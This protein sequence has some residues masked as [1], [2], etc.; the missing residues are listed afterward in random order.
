[1]YLEF[2]FRHKEDY[3]VFESKGVQLMTVGVV[4]YD[5]QKLAT[6]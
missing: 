5:L 1:M 3:H 2:S 6:K 4:W